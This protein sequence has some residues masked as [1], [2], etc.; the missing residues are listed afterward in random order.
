[1]MSRRKFLK[2]SGQAL[3]A[4]AL[5]SSLGRIVPAQAATGDYK[6][7]VC[8]FLAGG[9]DSNNT[10]IP[11]D[12]YAAYQAVR[13]TGA[14]L[15]IP[16]AQLLQIAA[17]SHQNKLFGLHPSL[18]ELQALYASGRL[19]VLANVGTLVRPVTKT[20][21]LGGGPRPENLFSHSDQQAQW[22]AA[23]ASS[24]GQSAP[25]GWGGRLADD[26]GSAYNPGISF[27]MVT[28]LAGVT[29]FSAGKTT[30]PIVPGATLI[31]FDS[32]NAVVVAAYNAMRK[33]QG[34]D[35]GMTLVKAKSSI[36][37]AAID[38]SRILQSA[39]KNAPAPATPFPGTGIG[40]QLK[41]AASIIAARGTI[42]LSR[43]IFFCTL[44]G[45]DTHAGQAGTQSSLLAQLSQAMK[46]F[47]EATAELG[48][49][50]NVTTFTLSDF[51]RTFLPNSGIGTDHAWGGHHFVMG[52]AVN[53]G[54]FYGRFPALQLK[55]PDD[56]TGEGRWIPTTSVD[57]YGAK[58]AEWF[59]ATDLAAAFPNLGNF[60]TG[61]TDLAF[62]KS[63]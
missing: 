19:A 37:S 51:N 63:G 22:Q 61:R 31:G 25:T 18:P 27:P 16:Q 42:G 11:Y 3:G 32:Q 56:L 35:V 43:Q 39:L 29:L 13:G 45:F 55:G 58:L 8:I 53:G 20:E 36:T 1:M 57:E 46:A 50:A 2:Q 7:L 49:E 26:M 17:A 38:N 28:S 5:L 47:Y 15:N 40:G 44:G 52:G 12:D 48:V 24:S 9:N 10:V 54:D 60:D 21:L 62:M 4:T 33:L 6:A 14:L 30:S 34:L 41:T 23:T 59:G